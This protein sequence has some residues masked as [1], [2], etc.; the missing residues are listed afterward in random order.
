M[1]RAPALCPNFPCFSLQKQG[2]MLQK[3]FLLK[4]RPPEPVLNAHPLSL[5]FKGFR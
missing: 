2:E 3:F 1:L 5:S 4:N